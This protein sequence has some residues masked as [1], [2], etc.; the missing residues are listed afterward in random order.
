MVLGEGVDSR[1][2]AFL[3]HTLHCGQLEQGLLSPAPSSL[4]EKEAMGRGSGKSAD[5]QDQGL[6]QMSGPCRWQTPPLQ[7]R[8]PRPLP[9]LW[10]E[11]AIQ[12]QQGVFRSPSTSRGGLCSS[13][14]TA[15]E[16]CVCCLLLV[17][18]PPMIANLDSVSV[19]TPHVDEHVCL[20]VCL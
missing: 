11:L 4:M 20:S 15:S 14:W 19:L 13:V 5:S 16:S 10:T 17:P 2:E 9:Q 6:R 7:C 1:R 3:P 12:E 18:A 8:A